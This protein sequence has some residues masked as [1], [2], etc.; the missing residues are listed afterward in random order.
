MNVDWTAFD[1]I[2]DHNEKPVMMALALLEIQP[3]LKKLPRKLRSFCLA[4]DISS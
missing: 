4:H 2:R 3:E 1:T